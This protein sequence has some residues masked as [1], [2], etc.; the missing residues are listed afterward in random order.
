MFCVSKK[1]EANR[2]NIAGTRLDKMEE[3]TA[4]D[5]D[6][7]DEFELPKSGSTTTHKR[8]KS[9][10]LLGGIPFFGSKTR[11]NS[12]ETDLEGELWRAKRYQRAPFFLSFVV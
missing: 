10:S 12:G 3:S 4:I 1:D 2:R 11:Q 6:G 5:D 7:A 8:Q 9:G